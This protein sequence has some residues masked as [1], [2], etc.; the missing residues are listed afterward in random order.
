MPRI[1]IHSTPKGRVLT[2]LTVF[3]I[4]TIGLVQI[5][6]AQTKSKF[7]VCDTALAQDILLDTSSLKS[8]YRLSTL[9]T[10][11]NYQKLSHDAGANAILYG[12]PVGATYK[13]YD[14]SR[15]KT[16][17]SHSE[18]Q[19]IDIARTIYQQS[20]NPQAKV[21]YPACLTA[22]LR[23]D[24]GM[25]LWIESVTAT[26]V[27]LLL[28]WTPTYGQPTQMAVTWTKTT[29]Q[30]LQNLPTT[31]GLAQKMVLIPRPVAEYTLGVNS[32]GGGDAVVIEPV[33]PPARP[34]PPPAPVM[35]SC[36][37]HHTLTFYNTIHDARL[38]AVNGNEEQ[39]VIQRGAQSQF[40]AAEGGG[41]RTWAFDTKSWGIPA[42]GVITGV[43]IA[44]RTSQGPSDINAW[45]AFTIVP[46]KVDA[47]DISVRAYSNAGGSI[48]HG[49]VTVHYILPRGCPASPSE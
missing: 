33:L 42:D 22:V 49:I 40:Y 25:H 14:E 16:F 4:F 23:S 31:I 12:V 36:D 44:P 2:A 21:N 29:T 9:V 48:T 3:S 41:G 30:R 19:S 11:E 47:T 28:S 38:I 20:V 15:S 8:D 18:S 46:A 17:A 6:S 1:L 43:D 32:D 37:W 5:A 27:A 7:S 13:D 35:S 10:V 45:S 34:S 26:D 39:M 24:K